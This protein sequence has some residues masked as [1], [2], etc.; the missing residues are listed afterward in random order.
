MAH[1]IL[2]R[3]FVCLAESDYTG[4]L[5]FEAEQDPAIANPFEY[6]LMARN[7]LRETAGM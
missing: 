2:N 5:I 3:C 4:W 1:L 7:Y 6:A